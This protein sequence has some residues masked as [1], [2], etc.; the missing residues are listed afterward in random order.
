MAEQGLAHSRRE[1]QVGEDLRKRRPDQRAGDGE[2]ADR[3]PG[4]RVGLQ[5][6]ASA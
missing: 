4:A 2:Q 1:R 5:P 3:E 6:G